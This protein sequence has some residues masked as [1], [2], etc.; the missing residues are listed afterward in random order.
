MDFTA[1]YA[2]A[3]TS[4]LRFSPGSTFLASLVGNPSRTV[5][6]RSA[7]SL[8]PVRSW[9]LPLTLH[10]LQWSGDGAFLLVTAL[11]DATVFVLS[12]DPKREARHGEDAGEG[13]IA[14]LQAGAEGLVHA[15]WAPN[16]GPH[17]VLCFSE[18]DMRVTAWQLASETPTL[19]DSPKT[20]R[21][22][23]NAQSNIFALLQRHDSKEA[24][25]LFVQGSHGNAK[26]ERHLELAD[27]DGDGQGWRLWKSFLIATND[28]AGLAW[29]PTGLHI[30][31]WE[32]LL[33]YKLQLYTIAGQ[34][35][36]TFA[37]EAGA[38]EPT[39]VYPTSSRANNG[40]SLAST[41]QGSLGPSSSLRNRKAQEHLSDN[42]S[43]A[44]GG[45][46]I[47]CVEFAPSGKYLAVGGA[48]EK[49]WILDATDGQ[50]LFVLDHSKKSYGA[51]SKSNGTSEQLIAWREPHR[52]IEETGG[53]G[54]ITLE[55][56]TLPV[57]P[58]AVRVDHTKPFP[59]SG[60]SWLS[61]SPDGSLI[62]SRNENVPGT[63][64]IWLV[65]PQSASA[66]ILLAMLLLA[67]PVTRAC[68]QPAGTRED[69]AIAAT[70]ATLGLVCGT[71]AIYQW[72]RNP[73]KSQNAEAIPIP[74]DGFAAHVLRWSPDG[75]NLL[76]AD[77]TA[78]AFCCAIDA[79]GQDGSRSV[80][81]ADESR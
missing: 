1:S 26:R 75:A 22:Y 51:S 16:D 14:R 72:S 5:V 28:A 18:N 33:E 10:S 50:Q 12:L 63:I 61:W 7:L 55:Q 48:D 31:V 64:Y 79:D 43:I 2:H 62:A 54:I 70:G 8:T 52:W 27:P 15:Q 19:I 69:S 3:S 40:T 49:L 56:N 76:L 45:L 53:R 23:S 36:A 68:W 67:A 4:S 77:A 58:P 24:V 81:I 42:R 57:A 9:D 59:K 39:T 60:V 30:A 65:E 17:T 74:I 25:S 71:S 41:Q 46:G 38:E 73:E 20:A 32:S 35:R 21:A 13:W 66:P 80:S 37:I 29:S 47:R 44:G 34:L 6:V 78:G 11:E